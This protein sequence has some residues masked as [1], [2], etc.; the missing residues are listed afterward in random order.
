VVDHLGGR[1][2][3][4]NGIDSA[5]AFRLSCTYTEVLDPTNNAAEV[6]IMNGFTAAPLR[7]LVVDDNQDTAASLA[8]LFG[9]WGHDTRVV[10]DGPAALDSAAEFRPD[11]VI[12]DIG[13]PRMDGFEVAR[14]LR[15]LPGLDRTLLV[16]SSGFNGERY[17]RLASEAGFDTYFVKPF[18]PWKLEGVLA[19]LGSPAEAVP[20]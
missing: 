16:A 19:S 20:A 14:R 4:R 8:L 13:L 12:L 3:S 18:D 1:P 5:W 10:H 6:V 15:L 11:A 9:M 17:R 2:P 7:V